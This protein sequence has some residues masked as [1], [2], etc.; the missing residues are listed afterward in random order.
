MPRSSTPEP[1]V[2]VVI[3]ARN[4]EAFVASALE[5]VASQTWPP[6]KIEAIVVVNGTQA[7]TGDVVRAAPARLDGLAVRIVDDPTPGVSRAKNVGARLARGEGL[8]FLDADSR[9]A[10]DPVERIGGGGGAGG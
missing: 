2:S 9:L 5:S 6:T 3:P 7:P 4:E 10:P 8:V 1:V